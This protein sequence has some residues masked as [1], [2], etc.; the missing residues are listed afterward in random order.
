MD[1]LKPCPFC[2]GVSKGVVDYDQCG[3]GK[4]LMSAYVICSACGVYHSFYCT[5][6]RFDASG[7]N[8]SDFTDAFENV[9]NLWNKRT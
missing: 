1:K 5:R 9:V 3:E 7:K 4:L 6:V 2:G 8:F